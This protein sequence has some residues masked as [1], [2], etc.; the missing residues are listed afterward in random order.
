MRFFGVC[1]AKVEPR[2]FLVDR[3][4][5]RSYCLEWS[6]FIEFLSVCVFP[7]EDFVDATFEPAADLFFLCFVDVCISIHCYLDAGVAELCLDVFEVE[8]A[9]SFHAAGHVVAEHV[10]G[11]G[12]TEFFPRHGIVGTW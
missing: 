6:F 12:N 7:P 3:S 5:H 4:G 2:D 10:E 9:G 11:G 1:R 8:F